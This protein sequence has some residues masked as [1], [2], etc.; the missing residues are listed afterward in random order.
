MN[1]LFLYRNVID[2]EKGGVQ[3]V[4]S[5]L[6]DYFASRGHS[7]WY[8]SLVKRKFDRVHQERQF[9]FPNSQS[10]DNTM[11]HNFFSSLIE[12]KKI[13]IVINQGGQGPST[14]KLVLLA[15]EKAKVISVHHSSPLAKVMNFENSYMGSFKKLFK[16]LFFIFPKE[17][18]RSILLD[19]Y[20]FKY[21]KHFV[22]LCEKSDKVVL[23]SDKFKDELAFL[24]NHVFYNSVIAIPNPVSFFAC[25]DISFKEK[26]IIFVGRISIQPKRVDLLL[27]IWGKICFEYPDWKLTIVG[28]G[29]VERMKRYAQELNL[30]NVS[31]EGFQDP[32]IYYKRASLLCMTSSF[33]GFGLVLVEAMLYGT[34]PLAFS[35]YASVTDIIDHGKNGLLITPFDTNEYALQLK[36]LML[37]NELRRQMS[38]NAVVKSTDFSIERIGDKWIALMDEMLM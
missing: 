12:D 7:V 18:M 38:K 34:V 29:E 13:D 16:F 9:I 32:H 33:E 23:L 22:R 6:A 5:V 4:T 17:K 30:T 3:R 21:G 36:R 25:E 31:F 8:V 27:R 10:F 24:T 1:I 2:P 20:K 37:D 26:E 35:S 28:G 14:F 15:K 19:I 11:N